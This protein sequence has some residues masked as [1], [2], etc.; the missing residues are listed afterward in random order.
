MRKTEFLRLLDE[1]L[2]LPEGTLK[3]DEILEEQ[4]WNSITAV[5][6]LALVDEQFGTVVPPR[7][8]AQCASV[9]SL[10]DLLEG[11]VLIEAV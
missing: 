5:G 3:G 2:E 10:I 4:G 11:Q 6:F 1:L 9:Q 8:L 7:K